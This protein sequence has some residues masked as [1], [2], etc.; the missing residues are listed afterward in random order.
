MHVS[1]HITKQQMLENADILIGFILEGDVTH[2]F[3]DLFI[4]SRVL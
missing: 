4:V 1:A 3:G 2:R